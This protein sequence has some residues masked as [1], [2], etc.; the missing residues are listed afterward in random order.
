M[1]LGDYKL[2]FVAAALIGSLLVASTANT[3]LKFFKIFKI[4]IR[5][6]VPS[7]FFTALELANTKT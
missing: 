3:Q 7:S 5:Q 2:I 1:K 6:V 4:I